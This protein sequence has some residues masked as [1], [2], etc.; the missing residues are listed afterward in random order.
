M[1]YAKTKQN[2]DRQTDRSLRGD[3]FRPSLH[4]GEGFKHSLI[5]FL[6]VNTLFTYLNSLIAFILF[7]HYFLDIKRN[8]NLFLSLIW[9]V[10][11]KKNENLCYKIITMVVFYTCFYQ[12]MVP[13]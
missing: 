5:E 8:Q 3:H 10:V 12:Q 7:K 11:S 6:N 13:L 2:F 9:N 4:Q 1:N